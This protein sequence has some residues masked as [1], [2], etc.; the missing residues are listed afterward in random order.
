MLRFMCLLSLPVII[1]FFT[2]FLAHEFLL[3]TFMCFVVGTNSIN[4]FNMRFEVIVDNNTNSW[5]LHFAL[6]LVDISAS[7]QGARYNMAINVEIG[8]F[9]LMAEVARLIHG[10]WR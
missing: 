9:I 5:Q 4:T 1:L 6:S 2:F 7:C 8:A 3:C 10:L